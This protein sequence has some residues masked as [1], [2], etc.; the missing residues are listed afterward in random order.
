ME[1]FNVGI[2]RIFSFELISVEQLIFEFIAILPISVGIGLMASMTG[3]SGG[4][5]KVPVLIILFALTAELAS[6]ASLLSAM[7]VAVTSSL[8]Y[9]KQRPMPIKFR[10]GFLLA[11][12]TIPGAYTGIAIR[13]IIAEAHLLRLTFG[14]LLLPI[15]LKLL[16]AIPYDLDKATDDT[17][18][19]DY[20]QLSSKRPI[21]SVLATFM[22]GVSAGILGLGGGT[23]IVPVL[24]ILLNFPILAAA[25][26]SMF[27]MIFTSAA[28]SLMNY[29]VFVQTENMFA[30]MFYGL[31]MG[32]GMIIGGIIG[33]KYASKVDG[34][35]LQR[36]FA[37]ILIFPIIKMMTL[38]QLWLDPSDSNYLMATIGDIIIWLVIG[39]P[40]WVI[41]SYRIKSRN[42]GSDQNNT[43][44]VLLVD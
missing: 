41:T 29:Y 34:R 39:V 35:K 44:Q 42:E 5:F 14:I 43:G 37:F 30:F 25:A 7:F 4:A 23:I 33:P 31:T 13:T 2:E 36:F 8:G 11:I 16:F 17:K 18:I 12:V 19:V 9:Y 26:T 10:I 27:V 24:C 32:V 38:G 21:L 3:I 20:S 1:T 22:A 15:A 40:L 6:A 28:G